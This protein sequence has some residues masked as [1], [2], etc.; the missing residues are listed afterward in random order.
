M[1]NEPVASDD[2]AV[3]MLYRLRRWWAICGLALFAVTWRLWV[4]Q[5]VFPQV[6]LFRW[7]SVL[8]S[9]VDGACF[10]SM[11]VALIAA[12]IGL[13]RF[14]RTQITWPLFAVACA[15]SIVFDQHRLQPWA[16][17]LLL[18][19]LLFRCSDEGKSSTA[20]RLRMPSAETL[21]QWLTISIYF[22]SAVSKFDRSFFA[23]HGPTLVEALFRSIG[24]VGWPGTVKW[25]LAVALPLGELA[26][27][28]GLSWPRGRRLALWCAIGLHLALILAL[29]PFRLGHRPGVLLWNVAFI[30][31]DWLLFRRRA[32]SKWPREC[33][34]GNDA[35][36]DA[37]L[38]DR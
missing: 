13:P 28:V 29:G 21:L 31:H 23:T 14:A 15:G 8:P 7:G 6:P 37:R 19:S 20:G 3:T 33:P 11:I 22:W 34:T 36:S 2:P 17:L 18:M 10:G 9:A 32:F 30:G 38:H 12:A 24:A 25:W 26:I 1:L 16:W 5:T 4:P 35:R 27:A